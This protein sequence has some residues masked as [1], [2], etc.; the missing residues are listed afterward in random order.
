M[1]LLAVSH[2]SFYDNIFL[3]FLFFLLYI[4]LFCGKGCKSREQIGRD[5][6]MNGIEMHD[7]KDT[8]NK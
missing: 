2:Y 3:F 7:V 6:E 1:L 8:K 4:I 5:G